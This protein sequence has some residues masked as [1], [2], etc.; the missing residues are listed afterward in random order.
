[1]SRVQEETT[2]AAPES[3]GGEAAEPP[4]AP[5]LPTLVARAAFLDVRA[6]AGRL[7]F[8]YDPVRHLVELRVRFTRRPALVLVDLTR[9]EERAGWTDV[10]EPLTG[11]LLFRYDTR[12]HIIQIAAR[13]QSS[14]VDLRRY[15]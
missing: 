10:E 6:E 14:L 8:R 3:R 2:E 12:N 13:G 11:H 1:M 9:F 5:A 7:L 4:Q 15:H